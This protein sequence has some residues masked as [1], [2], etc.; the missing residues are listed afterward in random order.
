MSKYGYKEV[1]RIEMSAIRKLCIAKDWFTNGDCEEYGN[2]LGYAKKENITTDD[3]VEMA[4][5]IK[6]HS[7]TDY[8]ITSIMFELAEI[9]YT[10]FEEI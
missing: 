3:L 7:N 10:F 9:C 8:E 6:E 2:L 1:R 4:E 5:Q